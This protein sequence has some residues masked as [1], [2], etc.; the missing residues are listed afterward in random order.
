MTGARTSID[1][2]PNTH[3]AVFDLAYPGSQPV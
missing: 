1:A 2:E 3:V